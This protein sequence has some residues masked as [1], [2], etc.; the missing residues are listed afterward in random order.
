[1]FGTKKILVCEVTKTGVTATLYVKTGHG[2]AV[3]KKIE[4]TSFQKLRSEFDI[5]RVRIV[6]REGE[7]EEPIVKQAS[8]AG[9]IVEAYEPASAAMARMAS[10]IHEPFLLVYPQVTPEFICAISDGKVLDISRVD[11]LG[12]LEDTKNKFI[13]QVADAKG[14]TIK[15]IAT[16]VPDPLL[17]LALKQEEKKAFSFP[18]PLMIGGIVF[19]LVAI[20]FFSFRFVLHKTQP[21]PSPTIAPT[22]TEKPMTRSELRVEVQNGSGVAGLAGKGKKV[23]EE[24]GYTTV[25]TA[26]ADNYD[27][28]GVTVKAKTAALAAFV[29]TDIAKSYPHA[30]AS[31]TLLDREATPDAI[32]IL[33]K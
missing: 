23:L 22:P 17:G 15:A 12:S 9:L 16:N 11:P 29:L 13:Q 27:Y 30:T 1:M 21:S 32:M 31:S 18:L 4:H 20:A 5:K 26:N 10:H 33:G 2:I 6:T 3:E 19:L 7:A 8:E 14:I 28:Q 24:L 25:T